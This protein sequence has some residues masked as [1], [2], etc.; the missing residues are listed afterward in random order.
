V[1]ELFDY[2]KHYPPLRD[3]VAAFIG[4]KPAESAAEKS[5]QYVN[6]DDMRRIMR[7]TGGKVP[8]MGQR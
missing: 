4:F 3:L 8:G 6:A 1:L 2:W 5:K 7:Q